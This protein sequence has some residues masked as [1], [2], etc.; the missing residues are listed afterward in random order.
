LKKK[1]K[2]Y[3]IILHKK[4]EKKGIINIDKSIKKIMLIKFTEIISIIL[5]IKSLKPLLGKFLII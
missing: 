1:I 4:E 5:F 3:K 2:L